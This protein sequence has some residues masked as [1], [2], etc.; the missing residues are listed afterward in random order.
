MRS[1]RT[2]RSRHAMAI[3]AIA[4]S[5]AVPIAGLEATLTARAAGAAAVPG[6]PR[7][8]YALQ[9]ADGAA[10]VVWTAPASDGGSARGCVR[11]A[12]VGTQSAM[13]RG[14]STSHH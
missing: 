9:A 7:W 14:R 4:V 5:M 6:I 10:R 13:R 3:L 1:M 11:E 8:A 12:L 2:S